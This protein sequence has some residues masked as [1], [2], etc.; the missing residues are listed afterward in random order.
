MKITIAQLNFRIADF[1]G[2]L[3]KMRGAIAEARKSESN[4]IVFSEL[5]VCGYPPLDLLEQ[6]DFIDRCMSVVEELAGES[7]DIGIIVGAPVINEEEKGKRLRNCA[8]L[9]DQGKISAIRFKTLL[10]TYDIFDEYRYFE[11]GRSWECIDFRGFRIALTICE[12]IWDDQPVENAFAR[13]KL[14]P[15]SPL[16]HLVTEHP[17]LMI[18]ISASPFASNRLQARE[19]VLRQNVEKYKLPLLYCNQVGANTEIIFDGSSMVLDSA[20][21]V[22]GRFTP[23]EEEVRT[24]AV[25]NLIAPS[26]G[27]VQVFHQNLSDEYRL[28]MVHKALVFGIKDYFSKMGFQRAILGLSGGMDSALTLVLAAQAL[29]P[30][31]VVPVLMPSRYSSAHSVDDSI[32]LCG[33]LGIDWRKIP[34]D[35]IFS[36]FMSTLENEFENKP[37]DLTEENIQARIRGVILMAMANKHG[38]IL[39]NTSNKSEAAVGYATLY[40]DM[41]G[42]LSVLGDVYKTDVYKLARFINKDRQIIPENIFVKAPSAELRPDQKDSDS[43]PEYEVLDAILFRYIEMK[44]S[45][46][47]IAAAGFDEKIAERVITMVNRSEYKRFQ[48][49]PILRV[50]SKAFGLGRRFPLV[51]KY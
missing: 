46:V 35:P 37:A 31:N 17:H 45:L 20:G 18:N 16:E 21:R 34:I 22:V 13:T 7:E 39:L 42:G 4:L 1:E 3:A 29:G 36:E 12:D 30:E 6:K 8:I 19:E 51:A 15:V 50:T 38:L 27:R 49:P 2:N 40:G 47:T 43:L 11:P 5:S 28:E 41:N 24:Y 48:S 32:E 14:Y 23:F 26:A 9:L 33:N 25:E 10:P 44:E